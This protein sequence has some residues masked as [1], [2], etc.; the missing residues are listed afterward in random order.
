MRKWLFWHPEQP[1]LTFATH[2]S[3]IFSPRKSAAKTLFCPFLQ[4]G[5]LFQTGFSFILCV[6]LCGLSTADL[7]LCLKHRA[8]HNYA[9]AALLLPPHSV[10]FSFQIYLLSGW[11]HSETHK[12]FRNN[13]FASSE[14]RFLEQLLAG[15][16]ETDRTNE[17][18]WLCQFVFKSV[19]F[20]FFFHRR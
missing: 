18:S 19:L 5:I 13:Q 14:E 3:S 4:F 6:H 7:R 1:F 2:I 16:N 8:H 9:C 20:S 10:W 17:T 11:E 15:L 12:D